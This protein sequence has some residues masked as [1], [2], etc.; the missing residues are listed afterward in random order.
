MLHTQRFV[1]S[2]LVQTLSYIDRLVP[3]TELEIHTSTSQD[4]ISFRPAV[5]G[6]RVLTRTHADEVDY[7]G[8][9]DRAVDDEDMISLLSRLDGNR[10]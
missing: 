5:Q 9:P 4:A 10:R 7:P 2:S 6:V 3:G 8:S 1:T